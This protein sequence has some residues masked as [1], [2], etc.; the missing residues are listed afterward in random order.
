[1]SRTFQ[2]PFKNDAFSL[3]VVS[4]VHIGRRSW[5]YD[6][7]RHASSGL[8]RMARYTDLY[9]NLGD[10]IHWNTAESMDVQDTQALS[11]L[12]DRKLATGKPWKSIAGNHDLRSY[13]APNPGRTGNEWC[14]KYGEELTSYVDHSNWLRL[15][16]ITPEAQEYDHDNLTYKPM[17]IGDDQ[18]SWLIA[19]SEEVPERDVY[20]FY[21]APLPSQFP[22]H[23]NGD[24]LMGAIENVENIKGWISGHRHTNLLSDKY[25][26][27]N[28]KIQ[29]RLIHHVNV[30]T[31]GGATPG[32]ADDR[33][34]QPFIS[35]HLTF[36]P[37]GGL[38]IRNKDH[39]LGSWIMWKQTGEYVIELPAI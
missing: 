28:F 30:C 20:I 11:W 29:T 6:A 7:L 39:M 31:F 1:M 4:D 25:A 14:T 2:H 36:N 15:L 22:P 23:M 37:G 16:F 19:R 33:W 35:T 8:D 27:L 24:N 26:F 9:V 32:Y 13:G 21:H 5:T 3:N 34:G 10:L 38:E 18:V 12:S 17:T